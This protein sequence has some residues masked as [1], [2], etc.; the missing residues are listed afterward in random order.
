MI[1]KRVIILG[2]TGMLGSMLVDYLSKRPD[3][4]ITAT[5]RSKEIIRGLKV[6]FPNV[7]WKIFDANSLDLCKDINVINGSQWVINAIGII[8]PL[9]HC[10]DLSEV[11]KAIRINSLLP[12]LL[13]KRA[14]EINSKVLQIATDCVYS[15][16]KG[17]YIEP[18]AHD[19]LDIYGKTK[20][21]GEVYSPNV[22]HLRCSIIGPEPKEFKSLMEW[23]LGQNI[24]AHV[25]GFTNHHWNGLT[26]LHFAKICYGIISKDCQLSHIHHVVP[27]GEISKFD[28][29][30]IFSNYFKRNDILIT[31]FKTEV[32]IDRTL[33]TINGTLNLHLWKS[34][35]YS[36]PLSV[37]EM[38]RELA[39]Y[40]YSFYIPEIQRS[41]SIRNEILS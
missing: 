4:E 30:K 14:Q 3:L 13:A 20:S 19:A 31:P 40:D 6:Q 37:P 1:G 32:G 36:K 39:N 24:N 23:F 38:V 17:Q 27:E 22:F 34:A 21:L 33:S 2:G 5:V 18:D 10:N 9:I 8:K 26:T 29:L 16:N 35:G 11:E 25:D 41:Q 28:L 7:K 12:Y 15:G